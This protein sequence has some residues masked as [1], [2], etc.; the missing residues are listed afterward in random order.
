[1]A[2]PEGKHAD[3]ED[4]MSLEA[5]CIPGDPLAMLTGV[6][7]EYARMGWDAETIKKIFC[8]PFFLATHGLSQKF[9]MEM[10]HQR[11]ED[12]LSR[13]GVF[14]FTMKGNNHHV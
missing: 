4:P 5:A 10:I 9:G 13:C 11:I 1:M 3:P 2:L 6:I 12:T 14:R 8:D 7:E